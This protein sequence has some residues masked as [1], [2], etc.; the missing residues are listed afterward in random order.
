[1]TK[2]SNELS[3]KDKME[4]IKTQVFIMSE[5]NLFEINNSDRILE[6]EYCLKKI[7]EDATYYEII[8]VLTW[9]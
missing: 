2:I 3:E 1:M 5:P 6:F 4:L 8:K 7:T 9:M